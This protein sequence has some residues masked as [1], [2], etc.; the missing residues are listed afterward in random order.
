MEEQILYVDP[1]RVRAADNLRYGLKQSRIDSLAANIVEA[2][3]VLNA[4]EVRALDEADADYDL[5]SGFY[6]HAAV[7]KLNENGAG[8]LLP[9][10][11]RATDDKARI[12]HQLSENLERESMSP[13]DMAVAIDRL[14]K[15]GVER[16][17]IRRIF[18]RPSGQKG[19]EVQPASNAWVNIIRNLLDLPKKLQELV[20][21]GVIGVSGAYAIG[22][23]APDKR[24]ALVARILAEREAQ[25]EQESKD[26]EAFLKAE[27]RVAE[28]AEKLK[29][30]SDDEAALRTGVDAAVKA[31]KDS[32]NA[33]RALQ[34]VDYLNLPKE[35]K[36]AHRKSLNE[37]EAAVKAAQ[38]AEKDTKN[39]L[40]KA[41]ETRKKVEEV[42]AEAKAKLD[43]AQKAK[44]APKK[45]PAPVSEADVN[46]A[47]AKEDGGFV[48]LTLSETRAAIKEIQEEAGDPG[49]AAIGSILSR[50]LSGE[51]TT[52]AAVKALGSLKPQAPKITG[53]KVDTGEAKAAPKKK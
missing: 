30:V 50:L 23:V 32:M 2:G 21:S 33:F 53:G 44:A 45:A 1:T 20:H 31:T 10:V 40:A 7:L 35:E 18:A 28:A 22:K 37:A 15:D 52:K 17:D 36:E 43:A 11:V 12:Q 19:K 24:D 4:V 38:K 8:L 48:P 41:I 49:V 26:E 27:S 14:L 42:T 46:K 29:T 34:K 5:T 9:V 3:G 25:L 51:F 39:K 16:K 13:M 47:A 6:R